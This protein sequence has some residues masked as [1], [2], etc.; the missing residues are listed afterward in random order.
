MG[1]TARVQFLA[2]AIMEFFLF[3]TVSRLAL[4]PT[5]PPLQWILGAVTSGVKQLWCE[6]DHSP[7]VCC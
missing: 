6:T 7:P 2:G 5:Q 3:A 4:G 1:Q